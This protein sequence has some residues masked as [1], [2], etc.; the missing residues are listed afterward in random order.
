MWV[1]CVRHLD[2][3]GLL[4]TPVPSRWW[5]VKSVRTSR[6]SWPI[7]CLCA[8]FQ[9]VPIYQKHF[10]DHFH[11][12]IAF[13]FLVIKLVCFKHWG[14]LK[15]MQRMNVTKRRTDKKLSV[16][17]FWPD[18]WKDYVYSSN[19]KENLMVKYFSTGLSFT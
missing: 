7:M 3:A 6:S 15:Y 9:S 14:S 4:L 1:S 12:S 16:L 11:C 10:L 17:L 19:A 5:L 13:Y 2:R 8:G 18:V